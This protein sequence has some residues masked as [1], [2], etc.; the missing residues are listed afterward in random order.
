MGIKYF[1]TLADKRRYIDH[2]LEERREFIHGWKGSVQELHESEELQTMEDRIDY[3]S[4][5]RDANLNL[6]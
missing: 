1:K 6:K 3:Y 2:L 4:A 5:R